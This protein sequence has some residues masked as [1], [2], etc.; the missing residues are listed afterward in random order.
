M[1]WQKY[2][3]IILKSNQ[4]EQGIYCVQ[5]NQKKHE[6]AQNST[7][8]MCCLMLKWIRIQIKFK[9]R[10]MYRHLGLPRRT[11][12]DYESGERGIPP[13]VADKVRR[14]FEWNTRFIREMTQRIDKVLEEE[15]PG[16]IIK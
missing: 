5:S 4:T 15:F 14:T 16:G 1:S 8:H 6:N 10:D 2:K 9:P 11:Y 12:Q 13:E 3:K 7:Q